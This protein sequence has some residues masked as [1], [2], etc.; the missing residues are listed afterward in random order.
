MFACILA[1]ADCKQQEERR[2]TAEGR[3]CLTG[4]G[5]ASLCLSCA[6]SAV[7]WEH[8]C[9]WSVFVAG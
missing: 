7:S 2:F 9:S 6:A 3:L 4:L 8:L 5:L 1:E